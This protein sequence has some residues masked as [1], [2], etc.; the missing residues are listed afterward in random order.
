LSPDE[1]RE[2]LEALG[3]DSHDVKAL[4][5]HFAAA[6]ASGRAGHGF[7]RIEWLETWPRLVPGPRPRRVVDEAGYERWEGNGALG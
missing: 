7:R 5:D 6:E 2:R 1:A 4:F 3:F